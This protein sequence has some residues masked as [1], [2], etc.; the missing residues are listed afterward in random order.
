VHRIIVLLLMALGQTVDADAEGLET[1]GLDQHDDDAGVSFVKKA[2][3]QLL[4]HV[5][6]HIFIAVVYQQQT[7]LD[8]LLTHAPVACLV[9]V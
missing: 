3:L 8:R 4:Q 2:L 7:Q 6:L 9:A 1:V 5:Q